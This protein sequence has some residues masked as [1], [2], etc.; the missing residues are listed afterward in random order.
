MKLS[1]AL[2]IYHR[3]A[4]WSFSESSPRFVWHFKYSSPIS[5]YLICLIWKSNSGV[6]FSLVAVQRHGSRSQD[7]FLFISVF[8]VMQSPWSKGEAILMAVWWGRIKSS[9]LTSNSVG[10]E[11][12]TM[13]NLVFAK[14]ED[15]DWQHM[16]AVWVTRCYFCVFT[17]TIYLI[18]E[19][20][21]RWEKN[22][23]IWAESP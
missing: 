11:K 18:I 17:F 7:E 14:K 23:V 15:K 4:L 5:G 12:Q 22:F 13:Q 10:P 3:D 1:P 21:S 19:I 9:S 20:D 2:L 6:S 16:G 8:L